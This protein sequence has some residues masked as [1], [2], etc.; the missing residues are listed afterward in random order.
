MVD[1]RALKN[2]PAAYQEGFCGT[3]M[4]SAQCL[5]LTGDSDPQE[6]YVTLSVT[7]NTR[8]RLVS[9]RTPSGIAL[10][11]IEEPK[12]DAARQSF[13]AAAMAELSTIRLK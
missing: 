5:P 1:A 3:T 11:Y 2:D 9:L 8:F 12:S 7:P 4:S 13:L 6:G 10:F